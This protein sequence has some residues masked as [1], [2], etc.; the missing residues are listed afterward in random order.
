MGCDG[1]ALAGEGGVMSKRKGA[2]VT[3]DGID[4]WFLAYEDLRDALLRRRA[5][6]MRARVSAVRGEL[7]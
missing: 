5:Q 7:L 3:I 6:G 4:E 2:T 1:Q